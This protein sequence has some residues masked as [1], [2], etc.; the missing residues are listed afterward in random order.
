MSRANARRTRAMPLAAAVIPLRGGA[1][2]SNGRGQLL[3]LGAKAKSDG[4]AFVL[5]GGFTGC[6]RT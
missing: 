6:R 5:P 3:N 4:N 2:V 1:T